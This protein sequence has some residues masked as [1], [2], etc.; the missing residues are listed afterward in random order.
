M[1]LRLSTIPCVPH[2]D[3]LSSSHPTSLLYC[4]GRELTELDR[5]HLDID[6]VI[7]S[8]RRQGTLGDAGDG[9]TQRTACVAE[10]KWIGK[11]EYRTMIATAGSS[12]SSSAS[13][14]GETG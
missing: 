10:K 14:T 13:P 6:V 8:E 7:S 4:S 3:L 1:T 5:K 9:P 11:W 12:A 2:Q